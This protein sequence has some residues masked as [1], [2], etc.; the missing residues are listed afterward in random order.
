MT[1]ILAVSLLEPMNTILLPSADSAQLTGGTTR[2][3][4]SFSI[5]SE[6]AGARDAARDAAVAVAK[7]ALTVV[8]RHAKGMMVEARM[9]DSERI[10][11]R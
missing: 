11:R 10:R 5:T 6:Q 9:I 7:T 2:V 3:G 8:V 4:V 1:Y